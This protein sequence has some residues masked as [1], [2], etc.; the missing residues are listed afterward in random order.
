MD[1][2]SELL[3]EEVTQVVQF[4]KPH[5][6]FKAYLY[7]LPICTNQN[8]SYILD[9]QQDIEYISTFLI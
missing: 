4:V 7:P 2:V 1:G 5:T 9:A 8:C 6:F 3:L